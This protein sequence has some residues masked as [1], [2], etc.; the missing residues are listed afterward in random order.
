MAGRFQKAARTIDMSTRFW[1]LFF[2]ISTGKGGDEK[3][4]FI[5]RFGN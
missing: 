1:L 4:A 5:K 3:Q 2:V